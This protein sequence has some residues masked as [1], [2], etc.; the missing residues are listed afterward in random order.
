MVNKLKITK[1]GL[2]P[3]TFQRAFLFSVRRLLVVT[4][5]SCS[6]CLMCSTGVLKA[7][8]S[9]P[10]DETGLLPGTYFCS[11]FF[12]CYHN[13]IVFYFLLCGLTKRPWL[14]THHCYKLSLPA[15]GRDHKPRVI[16]SKQRVGWWN[17][18]GNAMQIIDA[19]MAVALGS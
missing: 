5:I 2:C 8:S 17:E 13:F 7:T 15:G 11:V 10:V 12:F 4:V 16:Q 1:K 6:G 14:S 19:N 9:P 18:K 3:L